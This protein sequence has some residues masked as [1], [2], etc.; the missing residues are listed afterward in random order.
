MF[1][2]L[3]VDGVVQGAQVTDI[4]REKHLAW[5]AVSFL[6]LLL[7]IGRLKGLK[8]II[9]L[10][11]TIF[12]VLKIMLPLLLKGY[13]PIFVSVGVCAL[14]SVITLV[15]ISGFSNKTLAAVAGTAGGLVIAGIIAY[16]VGV[17]I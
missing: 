3:S 2:E 5:V 13:S 9:G 16:F 14:A 6:L 8:A 15:L 4:L 17:A 10:A 11:V 7:I 1:L 12:A